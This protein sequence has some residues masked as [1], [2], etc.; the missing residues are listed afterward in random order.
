MSLTIEALISTIGCADVWSLDGNSSTSKKL[1]AST[2]RASVKK[3]VS[4]WKVLS[5]SV[6]MGE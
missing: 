1:G 2:K 5:T 6:E 4:A 3:I